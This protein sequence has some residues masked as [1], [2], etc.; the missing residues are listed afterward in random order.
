MIP[1]EITVM[2]V[3]VVNVSAPDP[4]CKEECN[5]DFTVA[6]VLLLQVSCILSISDPLHISESLL[7]KKQEFSG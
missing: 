4:C 7:I 6:R 5:E 2:D 3:N 1:G